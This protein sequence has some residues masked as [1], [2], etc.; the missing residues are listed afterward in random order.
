M[1]KCLNVSAS[2]LVQQSLSYN[3]ALEVLMNPARP[4]GMASSS[5]AKNYS[6]RNSRVLPIITVRPS[7]PN[8]AC[9]FQF[10]SGYRKWSLPNTSHHLI[11]QIP[12]RAD[13]VAS[14][15]PED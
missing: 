1:K 6:P 13:N 5:L 7:E 2:I 15:M 4:I 8:R 3:E 11:P 9:S 14:V 12:V 10:S